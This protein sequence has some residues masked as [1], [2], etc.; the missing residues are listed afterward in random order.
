MLVCLAA[1]LIWFPEH[2][3]QVGTSTSWCDLLD[4]GAYESCWID[5][6]AMT[7]GVLPIVWNPLFPIMFNLAT[8]YPF[9]NFR[10]AIQLVS[11]SAINFVREF[12]FVHSML[13]PGGCDNKRC[14]TSY[15]FL[16]SDHLVH[17][18]SHESKLIESKC[19]FIYYPKVSL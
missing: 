14:G 2:S 12:L 19:L 4:I 17:S 11:S 18:W 16:W 13:W 9:G 10:G 1:W 6:I 8:L 15:L 3:T 7:L 5:G